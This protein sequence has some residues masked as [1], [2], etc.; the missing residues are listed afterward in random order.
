VWFF[1]LLCFT[2]C[3][4]V[5]KGG[6]NVYF[7]PGMY[8]QTGQVI[9]VPKWP[10]GEFVSILA[11]FCVWTKSLM[12]NDAV[13]KDSTFRVMSEDSAC[14]TEEFQVP[15]QPSGR[16]V[17]PSG[18]PSVY[19][20]IRP[21]DVS[22]R[23]DIRQTSIICPDDVLLP[24]GHLHRIEKLLCQISP[25]GHFSST[26]GCLSVLKRFTDSF[27]VSRKG[28]SINRP[29]NVVSCPD[30]YLRK[31]SIAVQNGPSGRLTVM[32]RTLVHRIW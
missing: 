3:P 6:S 30:E 25:S 5:T 17:I 8:F 13:N 20:S 14:E 2:L 22:F 32:V 7:G 26:S 29:D 31:A 27:Q 16:C 9:F 11:L 21:D 12:C 28:R 1:S 19:C 18:H 10:K 24:S 4:F 15:C 23:P